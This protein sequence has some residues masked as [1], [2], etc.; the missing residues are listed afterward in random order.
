MS[1]KSKNK[2]NE[3][4]KVSENG[5]ESLPDT[6]I[7][8][9]SVND[10]VVDEESL[11]DQF[12]RLQADFAKQQITVVISETNPMYVEQTRG[13]WDSIMEQ[14]LNHIAHSCWKGDSA[15]FQLIHGVEQTLATHKASDS[16]RDKDCEG[17]TIQ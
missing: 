4:K 11:Q 3:E 5:S 17:N 9:E 10:K 15:L 2:K 7:I 13:L 8:D 1:E 16:F 12:V 14:V 6:E